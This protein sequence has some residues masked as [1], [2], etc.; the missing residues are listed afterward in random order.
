MV[1]Y[2][3]GWVPKQVCGIYVI[4]GPRRSW[5]RLGILG[6]FRIGCCVGKVLFIWSSWRLKFW[7]FLTP[8]RDQ[9]KPVLNS[10]SLRMTS[11]AASKLSMS[12]LQSSSTHLRLTQLSWIVEHKES[13]LLLSYQTGMGR[14]YCAVWYEDRSSQNR[15]AG[16]KFVRMVLVRTE[17]NC[18]LAF[19]AGR[20]ACWGTDRHIFH[21][22]RLAQSSRTWASDRVTRTPGANAWVLRWLFAH[23][24]QRIY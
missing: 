13:N 16:R 11:R 14:T 2:G 21:P 6:V 10:L 7:I 17:L 4:W 20:Q 23:R 1:L 12:S 18:V 22:D 5:R 24:L 19:L 9:A 3:T 15:A 8:K